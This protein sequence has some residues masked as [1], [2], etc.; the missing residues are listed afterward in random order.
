MNGVSVSTKYAIMRLVARAFYGKV[1]RDGRPFLIAHFIT[2]HCMC[3]C[4]S[5]LWK[6]ND[7][8]DVPL[9]EVQRLYM[10]AKQLGFLA[11]AFTG[12]EPFLRKDLGEL[13]RFAKREAHM[14]TAL[15]TTG[16]FLDRRMHE[17][18]PYVNMLLVSLDSSKA[19]RHDEIRGKPGL[20]DRAVAG[21]EKAR[22]FYPTMPIHI[23]TCV[24][25]GM[26]DEIDDLIQLAE[27]LEVRISF[28][29][30]T[31]FRNGEEGSRFTETSTGL[32]E[33]ELVEVCR[34]LLARKREGAPMV[35]SERYFQYFADGRP[36]YSCHH[37][38]L[39]MSIDGRGNVEDCLDLDKPIANIRDMPLA[40]IMELPRFGQL[41]RDAERCC[42]C[43]SPT[44][45]DISNMWE[46]PSIALKEGGIHLT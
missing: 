20:F 38:K 22:A 19:E 25:Q 14:A 32:A 5:C 18:L 39:C 28:D 4:P 13:V 16:W 2:N 21:I 45:I 35:N 30:I 40:K 42:T 7:W 11:V 8:K 37:P 31:E 44:M 36:G 12:G 26:V 46:T 3:S 15:F 1:R 10:E 17:V 9:A 33:E 24:Q 34:K 6:H 43:S 41:R 27:R 29:V 23:N